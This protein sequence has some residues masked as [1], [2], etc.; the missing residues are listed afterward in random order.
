LLVDDKQGGEPFELYYTRPTTTQ[1]ID[2][3]RDVYGLERT[4]PKRP[5]PVLHYDAMLEHAL[6]LIV[7]WSDNAFGIDGQPFSAEP[8]SPHYREDWRDILRETQADILLSM[9]A[10]VFA[11]SQ[12]ERK[13]AV[14]FGTS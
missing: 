7:G 3:N 6:A 13:P 10:Q 1:T 12:V 2:Y 5:T 4:D 9:A 11:G 14:P 8:T